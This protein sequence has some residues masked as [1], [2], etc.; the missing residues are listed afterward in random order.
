MAYSID[1][2]LYFQDGS[3]QPLQLTNSGEDWHLVFFSDD[4]EKIFFSGE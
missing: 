3:N 4:G 1:G 2:N